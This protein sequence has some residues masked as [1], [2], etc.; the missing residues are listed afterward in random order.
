MAGEDRTYL[1]CDC[2]GTMPL[3]GRALGRACGVDIRIHTH[4]CRTELA[5]F[6]A[7]AEGGEHLIVCCTQEAPLFAELLDESGATVDATFVNIRETA[8]WSDEASAATPKIA[9]LMA[10]AALDIAPVRSL[11]LTSHGHALILGADATALEAAEQIAGRLD[12]SLLLS[13]PI[14]GTLPATASFP[15]YTG[16]VT[17]LTG[18]LGAFRAEIENF[19]ASRPSGRHGISF[20][21]SSGNGALEADLIV[22]LTGAGAVISTPEKRDGY[23]RADPGSPAAVQRLLFEAVELV[24]EFDKP[25]YVDYDASL[26]A[27]ARSAVVGCTRCIDSCPAS[28]ITPDGDGVAID[29]YICGGCG[30]CA[31]VCPTGAAGYAIP[32]AEALFTRLR[33]L[34]G[35]YF[36]AGGTDPAVLVHDTRHGAETIAMMARHGRGLPA[37]VIP[38]AV[39]EVTQLGFDVLTTALAY[40]AGQVLLLAPPTRRDELE[41][42]S[43]QVALAEAVFDGLGYGSGRVSVI[44]E[45]DPDSVAALLYELPVPA[46][47]PPA[48]H[49]A[50]GGKRTLS[51]MALEHFHRHAP[52]PVDILDLP[53]G[54]PFGG[55]SID[56]EGCTLCLA[57]VGA[58]PTG[59]MMDNPDAPMLRFSEQACIQCGLCRNTCPESVITLEPRFNFTEAAR[60]EVVLKEEEPFECVACGKPFASRSTIERMLERLAGHPMFAD[61]PDALNRLR[62][63]EECRV[64]DHFSGAQPMARG[65]VR[66]TRTTEDYLEGKVD[67]DED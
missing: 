23:L 28:A 63:C 46:P 29:P 54:A 48:G 36:D 3:D 24:G 8:G 55:V 11:T 66:L 4:L 43:G 40:G 27:H 49:L 16:R 61:D 31:S 2:E 34:L 39:N 30:S 53:A 22:D 50:M 42:L 47:I 14:D 52:A 19:A 5:H 12:V 35:A 33:A 21:A 57:C 6:T 45:A 65:T 58:C 44:D 37:R 41:P 56:V 59:A 7:A 67:E 13:R 64:V 38:F 10:E 62:M 1:V 18:H 32:S 51:T 60:R 17:A 20:E 26:C 9:A 25:L 15:I